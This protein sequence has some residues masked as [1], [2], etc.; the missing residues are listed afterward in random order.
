MDYSTKESILHFKIDNQN[1]ISALIQR[2]GILFGGLVI[3]SI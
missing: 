2:N 1:I 3:R